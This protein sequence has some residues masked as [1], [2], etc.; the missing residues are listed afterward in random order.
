[1]KNHYHTLGIE[2]TANAD[3]IK[4]AYRK[5]ASQHHPDKGGDKAKFQ[6]IQVAY[7]V[8]GDVQKRADYDNPRQQFGSVPGGF[9][10]N[11]IFSMFGQHGGQRR[12]QPGHVRMS[13]WISLHDVATGGSRTVNLGTSQGSTTVTIDIPPGIN[14]G[15]NVQYQGLGPGGVDL[16]VQYR[17]HPDQTWERHGL[18]LIKEERVVIWDLIVGGEVT[19]TGIT[20][21]QLATQ[22]PAG[23]QPGSMLRLRGQGLKDRAGTQGDIFIRLVPILPDTIAP[24]IIDAIQNHRE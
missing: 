21:T 7:G 14:D 4:S 15:D 13:L 6:E 8:L 9:D 20:G 10:F 11:D 23:T 17:V 5:L 3:E 24:E 2:R 1:M 16:V 22:I 19:V 18:N 12:Q